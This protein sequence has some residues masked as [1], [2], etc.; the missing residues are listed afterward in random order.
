MYLY[1]WEDG[2]YWQSQEPPD[3][4]QKKDIEAGNLEVFTI[5]GG[6]FTRVTPKTWLDVPSP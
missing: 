2:R 1:R 3:E 5:I 4:E 6:K